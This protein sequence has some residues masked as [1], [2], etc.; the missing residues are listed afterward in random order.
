LS[1]DSI[2][3]RVFVYGTLKRGQRNFARYCQGAVAIEPA[4]ARGWLYALP[5]G[6]PMLDVPLEDVLALGTAD[7]LADAQ[8]Q[9]A[10]PTSAG[11]VS[12]GPADASR[13][14][15][16]AKGELITFDDPGPRLRALDRLE[17]YQPSAQSGEYWRALVQLVEPAGALAWTYIAPG[18]RL[19][20]GATSLG[21]VWPYSESS[22]R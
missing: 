10:P 1:N 14:F 3:A 6:Y 22:C 15:G 19:P 17:A 2:V 20:M 4:V 11:L 5:Q 18:G 9:L 13:P 8:R 12:L 16:L 7:A 21:E